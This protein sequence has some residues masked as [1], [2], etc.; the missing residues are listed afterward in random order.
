MRHADSISIPQDTLSQLTGEELGT[1]KGN[2]ELAAKIRNEAL[3]K[4]LHR[5]MLKNNISSVKKTDVRKIVDALEN[6]I[7][8]SM[9]LSQTLPFVAM[10][11][12]VPIYVVAQASFG[13][14]LSDLRSGMDLFDVM[15][16]S[17]NISAKIEGLIN[18]VERKVEKEIQQRISSMSI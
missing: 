2:L 3:S 7:K 18:L 14:L 11:N 1:L 12:F 8:A 15:E 16:V 6:A 4:P 13:E 5:A 17:L 10:I 9:H